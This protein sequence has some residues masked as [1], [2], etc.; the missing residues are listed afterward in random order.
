MTDSYW[1]GKRA[2]VTGGAGMVGHQLVRLLLEAGASVTVID[3]LS[4]GR[5]IVDGAGLEKTDADDLYDCVAIMGESPYSSV[6]YPA[7]D[8][9]FNLAAE[10][11][12]VQFNQSN[13]AWM[14]D[15]NL[16]VLSTPLE[17]ANKAG[18]GC[19]VQVSSVCV[20]SPE[21]NHPCREE[22]GHL[23]EPSAANAGY[24]WAKRMGE[25]LAMW[26]AA[27]TDM[28]VVI[29]RPSNIFG[30]KDYY[31]ER[32]HVIPA[33]IRKC[34]YDDVIEVN[35]TGLEEREFI[36]SGDV[37]GG[38]MLAAQHGRSGE[39]YNLGTDGNTIVTMSDLLLQIQIYVSDLLC[40]S[41]KPVCW[42]SLF[43]GGDDVRFSDCTKARSELGF[44]VNPTTYAHLEDVIK[45]YLTEEGL[46]S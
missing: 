19:F 7:A 15:R 38:M 28:R 1:S 21:H 33:M 27:E 42:K 13:N 4:R 32:A 41:V 29:V 18:V 34:V 36:W 9:V 3:N 30:P 20:Y 16:R 6:T 17:A 43:D 39:A 2:V 23:G 12:G 24:A 5:N 14:F 22:N 44:F 25:R 37:A 8:A 11:A 46:L 26:Y 35:G 40:R 31:D 45:E 10:V